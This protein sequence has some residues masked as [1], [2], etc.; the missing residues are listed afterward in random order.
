MTNYVLKI[1]DCNVQAKEIC[2]IRMK[3]TKENKC[4][5]KYLRNVTG[6]QWKNR[7]NLQ[8]K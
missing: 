3:G 5:R 6:S 2:D 8:V 7:Q 4:R 1:H